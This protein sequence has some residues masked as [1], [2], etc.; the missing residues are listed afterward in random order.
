MLDRTP[1]PR[2]PRKDQLRTSLDIL[3]STMISIKECDKGL[4]LRWIS[5][6]GDGVVQGA[7][8]IAQEVFDSKPMHPTRIGVESSQYSN[9][10]CNIWMSSGGKIHQSTNSREIR[11]LTHGGTLL[12][13]LWALSVREAKSRFHGSRDRLTVCHTKPV[14]DI[15]AIL[16]L[17]RQN[18]VLGMIPVNLDP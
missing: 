6:V 11:S 18:R 12:G 5:R 17:R 13:I 10:V 8:N 7:L 15:K 2:S 3:A 9:S 14:Q 1:N 4:R 16:P